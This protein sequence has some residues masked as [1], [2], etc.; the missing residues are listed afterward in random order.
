MHYQWITHGLST[1]SPWF[2][3][4]LSVDHSGIIQGLS[5]EN[6]RIPKSWKYGVPTFSYDGNC[7]S[8]RESIRVHSVDLSV[9]LISSFPRHVYDKLV[10]VFLQFWYPKRLLLDRMCGGTRGYWEAAL[11]LGRPTVRQTNKEP[12]RSKHLLR[13]ETTRI[14]EQTRKFMKIWGN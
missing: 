11:G 14:K 8:Y 2:I 10:F 3:H 1:D 12:L 4:G 7:P 13:N 5:M 6:S 9:V